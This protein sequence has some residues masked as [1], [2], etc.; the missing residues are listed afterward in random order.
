MADLMRAEIS[1]P[2]LSGLL[3][4]KLVTFIAIQVSDIDERNGSSA[5][6]RLSTYVEQD[7]ILGVWLYGLVVRSMTKSERKP[8]SHKEHHAGSK[9]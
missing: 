8:T 7:D 2:L 4:G 3:V 5:L 9:L 6:S 1:W